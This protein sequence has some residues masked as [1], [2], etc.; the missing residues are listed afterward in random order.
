MCALYQRGFEGVFMSG[1]QIPWWQRGS[2]YQIYPRSF[3]DSNQDGIGDLRGILSRLDYFTWLGI[4]AIWI[5]PI[6]PSP[7][8]DFG[9][10]IADFTDIDPLFGDLATF[11]ELVVECHRRDL[12]LI[13][14]FVPNHTSDQHPWFS[15]SRSS[16]ENARRDW[17]V[18][19]DPGPDGGPPNNWL[20]IF[21]GS[22]WEWDAHTGQ[23]YLHSF[24]KEQPDLNWRNPEVK[25]AMFD[26]VRFWLERGVDG[27]RID[28]ANFIMKDPQLRDNPLNTGQ[29]WTFNKSYGG[30]DS[31]I[32]LFDKGHP[33]LHAIYRELRL[34]LESYSLQEPRISIGEVQIDDWSE[35]V[36]YYGRNLDELHMPFNFGL[37]Y[38]PWNGLAIRTFVDK[39]EALLPPEAWP[40]FVL[41][42]HDEARIA[43]RIGSTQARV[44]MMLLLT[45]RGTATIYYGDELGMHNVDVPPER[46]VDCWNQELLAM[47]LS[48][49][50]AR[51]P[52]Q[53]G[54]GPNAE[55]CSATTTPWLPLADD[56]AQVNVALEQHDPRSPLSLT[57]ALLHLRATTPALITGSYRSLDGVGENCYAYL[58]ELDQQR[59]LIVLS[60]ADHEQSISLPVKG[61]AT[62]LISTYLDRE[63]A[64]DSSAFA[65]RGNEGCILVLEEESF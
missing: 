58:R 13:M 65:L 20:S 6:Y 33:D 62:I 61:K 36:T 27:L 35:W 56:Y 47:G 14:D 28:V 24:L 17:Y 2:I 22:A 37:L 8:A 3:Q 41:G 59:Y 52:M 44:G 46:S 15:E 50:P 55:F 7:M 40:C 9:Y 32:H 23:Y 64:V 39:I 49:D 31:Q 4:Q 1:H 60:F 18:W 51:T 5:C 53:W 45:L 57:R 48:R 38:V 43:S 29:S 34:L 54:S 19:A 11:D 16:R 10:D 63:G 42:S 12:K 21:G 26:V 30:Y 25:A